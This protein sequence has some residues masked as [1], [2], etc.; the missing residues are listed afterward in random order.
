[1]AGHVVSFASSSWLADAADIAGIITAL[2]VVAA[3]IAWVWRWSRRHVFPDVSIT[4]NGIGFHTV[5]HEIKALGASESLV[6]EVRLQRFQVV[7]ISR[8]ADRNAALTFTLRFKGM[9]DWPEVVWTPPQWRIDPAETDLYGVQLVS[10][11]YVEHEHVVAGV[12]LFE[13][14]EP[15]RRFIDESV[16]P[17]IDVF[18]HISGSRVRLPAQMGDYDRASWER[19]TG[20][21]PVGPAVGYGYWPGWGC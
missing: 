4:I 11:V 16:A 13:T 19:G 21:E 14:F 18:D 9:G 3:I 10:P 6:R 5:M 17:R 1:M 20:W 2:G 12:L 7:I 8:E 15:I